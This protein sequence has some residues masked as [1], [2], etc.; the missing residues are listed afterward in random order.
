MAGPYC[1]MVLADM[2][3]R[4]IKVEPPDGDATRRMAWAEGS[5]SPAFSALNRGKR[6]IVLDLSQPTGREVF[7]R[8]ARTADVLIENFRP[9]VMQRLGLDYATL[10]AGH[11]RLI[12]ASISGFG[13]TGPLASRG[14][15]DLVAQGMSGIMSV[16]GEPGGPPMKAGVP[17]TGVPRRGGDS[18]STPRSSKPVWPCRR[19]K[20][21]STFP[22]TACPAPWARRIAWLHRIR[23]CG[24]AM[25]I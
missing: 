4:V 24:A 21:R 12:Y 3:A 13:Q 14:G 17:C 25:V 16:T 10:S 19:G 1:A 8:L 5:D 11:P 9:G 22:A 20:R 6:S 18:T 2:G 15:F 7:A 23:P